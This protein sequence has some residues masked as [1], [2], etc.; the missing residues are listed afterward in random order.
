MNLTNSQY[1]AIQRDYDAAQLKNQ[2]ILAMRQAEV[3]AR[4]PSYAAAAAD[5]SSLSVEY[6]RRVL[7]DEPGAM[8]EYR[9]AL[10]Q[11]S[12]RKT[13][14]LAGAGF[15]AD[16]LEPLF[17]CPD[18]KDTGYIDGR[19]CHC[20]EQKVINLLYTQSNLEGLLA[21]ENF[22]SLSYEYYKGEDLQNFKKAVESSIS[23]IKGFSSSYQNLLFYG[24]VGT[25]KTFLSNCIA[26]ELLGQG[27][28]VIY[29]SSSALFGLLSKYSFDAGAKEMLYKT[30][31]DLYNCDLV[32]VD[33]LGTE[34]SNSFTNSQFFSFMNE[35]HL[36]RKPVII[37]TNLSLE[38]LKNRYSERIVSRLTSSFTFRKITGPDIRL[39][40][41]I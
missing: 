18:C 14:L 11:L 31:D 25:G 21:T 26:G 1:D 24:E 6:G 7:A 36:R 30:Y 15:P 17:D 10:S 33:D 23:F 2:R 34:M 5:V 32:I 3:S 19:R 39:C 35:R 29:F 41:N 12:Q 22:S 4:C 9:N 27:Y 28:S 38:E 40:K 37:S 20:F 13:E 8:E 16:Y